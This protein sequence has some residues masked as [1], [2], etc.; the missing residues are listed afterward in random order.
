MEKISLIVPIYNVE[1]YLNRC[2]DSIIR[3]TYSEIEIILINDGSTDNCLEIC[4]KYKKQDKRI[5]VVDKENGGL[6]DA[7]NAGIEIATGKYIMFIDSDDWI[8]SNMV[9]RLYSLIS[10]KDACIAQCDFA[11]VYNDENIYF[12][13]ENINIKVMDSKEAMISIYKN[14]GVKS[15]VT[16]NK[17]Y[18]K[19]LFNTIRFPKGKIHEDEFTTYK[20]FDK[21][22]KIIDT[23]EVMYYYRQRDGS[24]M[25]SEFSIKRLDVIEAI[26][27]RI[28][29]FENKGYKELKL[30]AEN[31]LQSLLR[32]FYTTIYN[33][34]I[35]NKEL[36]LNKIVKE[37][38]KNYFKFIS[39]RHV[40]KKSK[41]LI[42]IISI[43]DGLYYKIYKF[44]NNISRKEKI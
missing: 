7:R 6:S 15:I 14:N 37:I 28:K 35:E 21:C 18:K 44:K 4:N 3:Q 42:T 11:R 9:N 5:I 10:K 36:Y 43:N 24:I 22:K 38:R 33:S 23:D 39:N 27:E 12:N 17:I 20:L 19:E 34:T 25:K 41:I 31:Q 16:W 2:V 32:S 29:Y 30:L 26:K 8:D 13:N 40:S 1:K